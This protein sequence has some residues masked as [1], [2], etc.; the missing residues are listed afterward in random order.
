MFQ[1][2]G[3]D[4]ER[5][6]LQSRSVRRCKMQRRMA[7]AIHR[8]T[9][10]R[11]GELIGV[12]VHRRRDGQRGAILPRQTQ[13]AIRWAQNHSA[14]AAPVFASFAEVEI[15]R[16]RLERIR[17]FYDPKGIQFKTRRVVEIEAQ[18]HNPSLGMPE[19]PDVVSVPR[20]VAGDGEARGFLLRETAVAAL[21]RV[22]P[23]NLGDAVV[24]RLEPNLEHVPRI[25]AH[26]EARLV[27]ENRVAASRA[28]LQHAIGDADVG[29][30]AV[31]EPALVVAGAIELPCRDRRRQTFRK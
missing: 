11:V 12:E 8:Q 26:V 16:L 4:G 17:R 7:S 31:R 24:I 25:G 2:I 14:L 21:D 13:R 3:V 22:A 19:G 20:V 27:F 23:E 29:E 5:Q 30:M 1:A 6:A 18:P 15:R 10:A 28:R 9:Q